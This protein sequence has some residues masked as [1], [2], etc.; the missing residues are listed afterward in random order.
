MKTAGLILAGTG[1][2]GLQKF[3]PWQDTGGIS[4]LQRLVITLQKAGVEPVVLVLGPEDAPV[5]KHL[6]RMGVVFVRQEEE[7]PGLSKL[8]AG[9]EYLQGIADRV[10]LAPVNYP[11]FTKNTVE[12]LLAC[13]KGA[14]RPV[15]KGK[16]GYPLL[17]EG[18]L[19]N[20][21]AQGSHWGE[22][23]SS[24]EFSKGLWQGIEVED[25]GVLLD[26]KGGQEW[27]SL[28]ET[29]ESNRLRAQLKLQ[30]AKEKIFFGPGTRLLLE[31]IETT[32]SVRLAC[33]GMGVSY[34]KGWKM[35][36]NMEDQLDVQLVDR[37]QGGKSG[38]E[39][40]LTPQGKELLLRYEKLEKAAERAVNQLFEEIFE[41]F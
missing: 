41:G 20:Q 16:P 17:V 24:G 1:A 39:A 19:V 12:Q 8:G 11:F 4:A 34:S 13:Q 28:L 40:H 21:L 22:L 27:D 29:H 23:E 9:L 36:S 32:G 14:A 38:G 25:R 2:D 10:L 26:V 6:A 18:M 15:Y 33:R 31:L 5:E 35:L 37:Q 7:Q 30:L 3:T